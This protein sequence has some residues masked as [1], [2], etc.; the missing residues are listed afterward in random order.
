MN[1]SIVIIGGSTG[2][3]KSLVEQASKEPSNRVFAF[4]R[5]SKL[6]RD[7]FKSLENVSTHHLDLEFF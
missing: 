3:G 7:N 4:A 2:I 1:K 5:K 6:M